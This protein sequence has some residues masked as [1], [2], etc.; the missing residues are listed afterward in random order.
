MNRL[1]VTERMLQVL[2]PADVNN[3]ARVYHQRINR[4]VWDGVSDLE[5]LYRELDRLRDAFLAAAS[6]AL[7]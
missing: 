4:A 5:D 2:Y 7:G 1:W 3:T 6:S